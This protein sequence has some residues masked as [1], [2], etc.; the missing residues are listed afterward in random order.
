[1]LTY[2][3]S[4]DP[5]LTVRLLNSK[6]SGV[7]YVSVPEDAAPI[8]FSDPR[9]PHPPFDGT[10]T[11]RPVAGDLIL[12]PSWLQHQVPPTPGDDPRLS[13]AFNAA[14]RWSS[15]AGISADVPLDYSS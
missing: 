2:S 12:F 3:T 13:I 11:I 7:Y 8:I 10:E 4:D 14:G 5:G 15:T 1:M 9:G 6:V